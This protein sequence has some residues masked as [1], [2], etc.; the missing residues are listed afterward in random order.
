MRVQTETITA[1]V[2]GIDCAKRKFT[3]VTPEGNKFSVKA[4]SEVVNF[5]QIRVRDQLKAIDTK[6]RKATLL[7]SDGVSKKYDVRPDVDL[8]KRKIGEK[9]IIR[10]PESTAVRLQKP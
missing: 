6:K 10:V 4:G 5:E 9:V 7:F 8:S 3:L 1:T 2:T